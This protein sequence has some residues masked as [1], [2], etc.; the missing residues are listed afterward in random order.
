MLL[1]AAMEVV[2]T[3]GA[4]AFSMRALGAFLDVDPTAMYRH[5]ATKNALLD[6]LTDT[7]IRGVEELPETDDPRR[8]IRENFRQLRRSLLAHPTLAPLVLR[9]PPGVGAYWE[10]ADHAVAQLHR[11]GMDPADAAN[12]YQTLLFYTLGHT[13]SE[14]RQLARA[15]EREGAGARGGPVAAVRPPAEHHPDLSDAAP[16]LREENEA[17]FLAGLDLILR[18]LPR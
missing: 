18:D 5:F 2:D 6:A 15:V 8:D 7:V 14:A 10:R 9:R 17:Q 3:H 4:G 13:L 16:H 11:A 1:A 12:V